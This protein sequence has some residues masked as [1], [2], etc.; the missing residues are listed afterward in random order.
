MFKFIPNS[1]GKAILA[2]IL[3]VVV[4]SAFSFYLGKFSQTNN[5]QEPSPSPI[6]DIATDSEVAAPI[7]PSI[8]PFEQRS[9]LPK[10]QST[11]V[12]AIPEADVE[13]RQEADSK[14][15]TDNKRGFS[16][17]FANSLMLNNSASDANFAQ[18]LEYQKGTGNVARM[19]LQ[20]FENPSNSSL[21]EVIKRE[22]L[23]RGD[24][25]GPKYEYLKINGRDS[26]KLTKTMTQTEIC[27][28]GDGSTKN[29]IFYFLVKGDKYVVEIHPN[30][31]CESFKRNWFD[32]TPASFNITK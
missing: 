15:Y 26:V 8:N 1:Q 19:V 22:G 14:V 30:D 4:L 5:N 11:S 13:I 20:I 6:E 23:L 9:F 32:V 12:P 24:E 17:K 7:S 28:D 27:N 10:S 2:I 16:F 18:F 29:R 31:S 25:L 3:V 21:D